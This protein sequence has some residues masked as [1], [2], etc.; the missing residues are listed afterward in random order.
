M[1]HSQAAH[2]LSFIAGYIVEQT[3]KDGVKLPEPLE[4]N[5]LEGASKYG[6]ALELARTYRKFKSFSPG[7]SSYESWAVIRAI[8]TDGCISE[9]F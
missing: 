6:E 3:I 8:Y 2:N 9:P 1:T 5:R 7:F 4:R